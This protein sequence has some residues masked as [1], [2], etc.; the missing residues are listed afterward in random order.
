[1]TLW[2]TTTAIAVSKS[3]ARNGNNTTGR[4]WVYTAY[5]AVH[6]T[7]LLSVALLRLSIGIRFTLRP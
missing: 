6:P 3:P 5:S 4:L 7:N 1:V 2:V